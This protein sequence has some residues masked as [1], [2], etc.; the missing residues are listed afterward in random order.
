MYEPK[1]DICFFLLRRIFPSFTKK[2][3]KK[4]RHPIYTKFCFVFF[5]IFLILDRNSTLT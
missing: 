1:Y 5:L 2:E 4:E 3:K